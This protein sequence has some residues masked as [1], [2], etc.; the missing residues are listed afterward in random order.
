MFNSCVV[1]VT[2]INYKNDK[3]FLLALDFFLCLFF[4]LNKQFYNGQIYELFF[5]RV[6]YPQSLIITDT[7]H[8]P[9]DF[10]WE[11]KIKVPWQSP[12]W[13][14]LCYGSF[15]LQLFSSNV[16]GN[17]SLVSALD[18]MRSHYFYSKPFTV[19]CPTY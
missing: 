12:L 5:Q 13:F 3:H 9:I 17:V 1:L 7:K 6:A 4:F 19:V 16:N 10:K 15:S 14:T 11:V 8:Q 18:N 2:L